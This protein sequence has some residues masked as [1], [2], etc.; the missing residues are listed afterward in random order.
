MT[1]VT[2]FVPGAPPSQAAWNAA[3][4]P[5]G[6]RIDG[7][8]LEGTGM[9]HAP[10]VM[11][12]PQ[13]GEFGAAFSYGTCSAEVIATLEKAPGALVI[14][15]KVDLLEG[16]DHIVTAVELLRDAGAIAVRL[17]QSKLGWDVNRWIELFSSELAN[18][19]HRGAVVIL[20]EDDY[21][22]S[23][24]MHL[25]SLPDARVPVDGDVAAANDL[26]QTLN[27]YQIGESPSLQ[28]GHTFRPDEETPRRVMERWP[29]IGYP[30]DHPCHNSYGVWRLGPAGGEARDVGAMELTF[31]PSLAAMLMASEDKKGAPLT[32]Q[33]TI[34]IRDAAAVIAMKPQDARRMERARGYADLN[35][36]LVWE[37]W[38]LLRDA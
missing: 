35:P 10:E 16:R 11:W 36:E 3:L 2:M 27:I 19:W 5:Q 18:D 17:E 33:E 38:Q 13:D 4:E 25:F 28:S 30:S 1:R 37:Q 32:E 31:I 8:V 23:C 9:E 22:Q 24:G 15:W 29:D 14:L 21:V 26:V 7:G 12:V 20:S 6:L 34:A